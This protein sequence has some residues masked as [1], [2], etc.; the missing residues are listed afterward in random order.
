MSYM[1]SRAPKS[2]RSDFS[3]RSKPNFYWFGFQDVPISDV[4]ALKIGLKLFGFQSFGLVPNFWNRNDLFWI[5]DNGDQTKQT[6][7][8][9]WSQLSDPNVRSSSKLKIMVWFETGFEP[10]PN[11]FHLDFRCFVP[12][13][14]FSSLDFRRSKVSE[15]R[16]VWEWDTFLS[17]LKSEL[18]RISALYCNVFCEIFYILW[19]GFF[20]W[21]T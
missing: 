8:S 15:I 11:R 17:A 12:F 20:T 21:P 10:V 6:E 5:L 1:Y 19:R 18:V 14:L 3:A 7:R 4:R 2:E 16:T 13:V 9:V